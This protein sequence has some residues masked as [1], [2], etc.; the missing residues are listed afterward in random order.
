MLGKE[1]SCDCKTLGDWEVM[2]VRGHSMNYEIGEFLNGAR[3]GVT[4]L[5]M[6]SD[7]YETKNASVFLEVACF[8]HRRVLRSA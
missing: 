7:H 5:D 2:T 4:E 3:Y 8:I 1:N 6:R